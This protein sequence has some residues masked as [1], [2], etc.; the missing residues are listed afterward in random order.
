MRLLFA[1]LA[2]LFLAGCGP[3]VTVI[4]VTATPTETPTPPATPVPTARPMPTAAPPLNPFRLAALT[5]EAIGRRSID[6]GVPLVAYPHIAAEIRCATAAEPVWLLETWEEWSRIMTL[7][8]AGWVPNA[9]LGDPLHYPL[10]GPP[11]P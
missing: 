2:A 5:S 10:P 6:A 7:E 3:T 8:C 4:V 11:M 1:L 9:N